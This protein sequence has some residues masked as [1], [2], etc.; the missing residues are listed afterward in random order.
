MRFFLFLSLPLPSYFL[1]STH[2]VLCFFG[3]HNVCS[4]C[5]ITSNFFVLKIQII[6]NTFYKLSNVYLNNPWVIS[7]FFVLLSTKNHDKHRRLYV[8]IVLIVFPQNLSPS[9][10]SGFPLLLIGLEVSPFYCL[11]LICTFLKFVSLRIVTFCCGSYFRNVRNFFD[12]FCF[13][14]L[15]FSKSKSK[16]L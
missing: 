16:C 15:D 14:F 9:T 13:I 3:N 5:F 4:G 8:C 11:L 2:F 10:G 6:N 12:S 1:F 7:P